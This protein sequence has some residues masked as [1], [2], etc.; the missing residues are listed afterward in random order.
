MLEELGIERE[1]IGLHHPVVVLDYPSPTHCGSSLF[2]ALIPSHDVEKVRKKIAAE[3]RD[4][5]IRETSK[6]ANSKEG[7][8]VEFPDERNG[9]DQT[10][11]LNS[12]SSPTDNLVVGFPMPSSS[13]RLRGDPHLEDKGDQRPQKLLRLSLMAPGQDTQMDM[14]EEAGQDLPHPGL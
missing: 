5:R 9:K 14:A 4:H 10:Q 13:K 12:E 3:S 8:F 2:G 11:P 6:R 7:Y 1:K